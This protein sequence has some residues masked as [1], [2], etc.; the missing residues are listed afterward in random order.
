MES[1]PKIQQQE[2]KEKTLKEL[3]EEAQL[4][5]DKDDMAHIK[6][7][8]GQTSKI[9]LAIRQVRRTADD[10]YLKWDERINKK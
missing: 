4:R 10:L 2:N 7:G 8:G 5:L 9:D 6:G 3:A 1:L